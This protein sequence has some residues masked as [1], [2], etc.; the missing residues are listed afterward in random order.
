MT[1][2]AAAVHPEHALEQAYIEKVHGAAEQ[3]RV[4]AERSPESAGDKFAARTAREQVLERFKEP[5]D[6]EALCFGRIDQ[7][8]G[9]TYYLGRGA[10]HDENSELLVINWRRPVASAFYTASRKDPQGLARRRRFQLDQLRLLGIVDDVFSTPSTAPAAPIGSAPVPEVVEAPLEPHVVDGILADM[11]RARGTEMRDIVAT[12]EARQYELIS[13]RIEG[14]LVIQ[15]GPGSGKTAIALHR[16]AWLLYNHREELERSRVLV[17]GPNRAFMEYVARVLPTLGE[18]SVVQS[19]I[20]RLPALGDV[21]ARATE[22]TAVAQLKGDIRMAAMVQRAVSARVRL[23][24]DDLAVT[25]GRTRVLLPADR[26]AAL[27]EDAWRGGRTYLEAREIFRRELVA[28]AQAQVGDDRRRFRSGPTPG[29]IEMAVTQP[30]GPLESVWPTVTPPEVVRD[31]LNSRQRLAAA[32]GSSLTENEQA[33]LRR[34]RARSLREEPWT[35]ADVPL[36]D[37]ADAMLRG[38]TSSYGYVLADEAQDLSPMQLRMVFRRT[39]AGRATLVGDI[40]QATGP[41]RFAD[42]TALL[43]AAAVDTES[44]IAELAIGYRVPRQIMELAEELIPRIA[45]QIVVPTAVRDGPEAPRLVPVHEEALAARV[46]T[47]A[48]SRLEGDRSV[49]VVVPA[50]DLDRIRSALTEAG[51]QAGDVLTDGLARQV[52]VLSAAQAKGLE[53]DHVVV[54]DPAGI[55]GPSEDWAHVYIALTRATRTLSVLYSTP[56]PFEVPS[57]DPAPDG[58]DRGATPAPEEVPEVIGPHPVTVLGAR[59]TEALMQAKFLHAGQHRRGTFVPYLAHLQA[60][61]ALV[62]EDGG[63]EDEA[64]AALLHDAVEDYGPDVLGRIVDQFGVAVARIVAGC[65]DPDMDAEA[66]WREQ[67]TQHL[68]D[69]EIAGP[70]VRRVALAEKL[71]N[72]RALLRD[73]RRV[74]DRLWARMDVDPE[75]LLWYVAALADLFV[76]ER[77]GDM[78]SE[79]QDTVERLLDLASQPEPVA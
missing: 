7:E 34:D 16:A 9:D 10:V 35:A 54:V 60:V 65:T 79:F 63:S 13:D 49:G 39:S 71:D 17:V 14:V 33:V 19:A 4:R 55:A 46:V 22:D 25:V 68:R 52:T 18:T 72:A 48:A 31:L 28:L 67:K 74:G 57:P 20:D 73:Y 62:L 21:R 41:V 45:P 27:V 76:T 30:G 64:I 77:P 78:A 8:S 15:G 43:D 66:S 53:F 56:E 70:Q 3:A 6:L 75:D 11:D 23:P 51:V 29:D 42:W 50:S 69:L 26:I 5:I 47:E 36:L 32:A 2:R 38:V 61:A 44:R 24:D 40:A 58:V 59:Y 37:E 12:I 1:R